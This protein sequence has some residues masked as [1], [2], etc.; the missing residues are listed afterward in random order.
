MMRVIEPLLVFLLLVFL[1]LLPPIQREDKCLKRVHD[2]GW[3]GTS[4]STDTEFCLRAKNGVRSSIL[5]PPL[6]LLKYGIYIFG[7]APIA[8][9]P[10]ACGTCAGSCQWYWLELVY[11]ACV[12]VC[13]FVW[14][15]EG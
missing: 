10:I 3:K 5:P 4:E 14:E 2:R 9:R 12:C 11:S 13:V 8:T 1:L 7:G 6:R 15:Y